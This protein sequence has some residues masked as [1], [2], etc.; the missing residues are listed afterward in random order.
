[1][2]DSSN[3]SLF[4]IALNRVKNLG[5]VVSKRLLDTFKSP[6]AV[7][8]ASERELLAIE[9]IRR[10][11]VQ[12]ILKGPDFEF[13]KRQME[14]V[15]KRGF[16]LMNY[17]SPE[18][19]SR[20][21]MI[22]APPTFLY[23]KGDLKESDDRAV[24]MVGS[25]QA[26]HY[27]RTMAENVAREL[28][29][30]G[31]TVVSGFAR[32]VDTISHK[33][34]LSAGGR[35]IAVLGCG[36]DVIYPSQNTSL[37]KAI[38]ENGAI[39][40]EFPCGTQPEGPNFPRRNRIISGLSLG[41]VI[42][43]AGKR[44]G[45]LLTAKHALD[46]NREV[47]AIPG[48]ITSITSSGTNTLLKQGAHLVT[49]ATDVLSE[50]KFMIPDGESSPPIPTVALDAEQARLFNMMDAEPIHVDALARHSGIKVSRLLGILLDMELKG[51]VTQV[52]GKKFVKSNIKIY[53][54]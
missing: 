7:F 50:L 12:S 42:V 5:P 29:Q 21:K 36:L 15:E 24:A 14:I 1:M 39:V 8:S 49:S 18:Y 32:G 6:E 40:S 28:A 30:S 25:R 10:S 37:Y 13:A 4:W 33:A 20:L 26:T 45:A 3:Q 31:I 22:Y 23:V 47:F 11:A 16:K 53:N 38:P 44:S 51:A 9:N 17:L 41:V 34:A 35:T 2:T 54:G 52:P 48:N 46:Q 27:G 43:E 19:P